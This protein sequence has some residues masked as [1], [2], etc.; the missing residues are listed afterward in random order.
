MHIYYLV[1][2]EACLLS[3]RSGPGPSLGSA[4]EGM[5]FKG[6][7][8]RISEGIKVHRFCKILFCDFGGLEGVVGLKTVFL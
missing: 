2:V 3:S 4:S 7:G 8:F 6:L 5:S 1:V